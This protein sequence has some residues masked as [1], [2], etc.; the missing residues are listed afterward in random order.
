MTQI[1]KEYTKSKITVPELHQRLKALCQKNNANSDWILPLLHGVATTYQ[2]Q[3]FLLVLHQ[4][5]RVVDRG[6]RSALLRDVFCFFKEKEFVYLSVSYSS[7]VAQF[8][9]RY[10]VVKLL[11]VDDLKVFKEFFPGT[12]AHY[13]NATDVKEFSELLSDI[14]ESMDYLFLYQ[15]IL[16]EVSNDS[17]LKIRNDVP[18]H[19]ALSLANMLK[20]DEVHKLESIEWLLK[21]KIAV[22][23]VD[24]NDHTSFDLLIKFIKQHHKNEEGILPDFVEF[25]PIFQKI[26]WLYKEHIGLEN[27]MVLTKENGNILFKIQKALDFARCNESRKALVDSG[28]LDK[29]VFSIMEKYLPEEKRISRSTMRGKTILMAKIAD[30]SIADTS[31][32]RNLGFFS[33]D[34]IAAINNTVSSKIADTKPIQ[35]NWNKAAIQLA[36]VT[37]GKIFPACP[38]SHWNISLNNH[39]AWI[40]FENKA[41]RNTALEMIKRELLLNNSAIKVEFGRDENNELMHTILLK[42]VTPGALQELRELPEASSTSTVGLGCG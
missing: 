1:S 13:A 36:Q 21:N 24:F 34:P 33:N 39:A 3:Q 31:N 20:A 7:G 27:V 11:S 14:A 30:T 41:A 12:Y 23:H 29:D 15:P 22:N 2:V 35:S 17:F 42:E 32:R 18:L 6:S 26:I 37:L 9:R 10:D 4:D 5:G 16:E 38:G 19:Y 40:Y 28:I 8:L 25:S